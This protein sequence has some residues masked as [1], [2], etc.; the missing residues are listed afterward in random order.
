[1]PRNNLILTARKV[2]FL[3]WL[4]IAA[5]AL[6]A[7]CWAAFTFTVQPV[8][9][10]IT[11]SSARLYWA[12]S[13]PVTAYIKYGTTPQFGK[14]V[15]TY[16]SDAI[17]PQRNHSWFLS[18]LAANTTYHATVCALDGVEICSSDITFTTNVLPV[19]H[20]VDPELPRLE[21]DTNMPVQTGSILNVGANCDDA[22][23]G[24]VARWTQAAW[25][26][27]VVI[28]VTTVCTG[29]YVFPAKT[30]DTEVPHRWIVTKSS[31]ADTDL[32]P[33]GTRITP[34][35]AAY[36]ASVRSNVTNISV[37]TL[38]ARDLYFKCW[39]GAYFW[40]Y[41]QP[42]FAMHQCRNGSNPSAITAVSGSGISPIAI[43]APNHGLVTGDVVWVT[44]IEGNTNANGSFLV[45]VVNANEV[46]LNLAI[47]GSPTG[48]AAYTGGGTIA[49]NVWVSLTAPTGTSVPATCTTGEWFWKSN[50]STAQKGVY[51][52]ISTDNLV[53]M[54]AINFSEFKNYPAIQLSVNS[55][56]HLRF[57]GLQLSNVQP[58]PEPLWEQE[59]GLQAGSA[60]P[61]L[62]F[63]DST[64]KYIVWDRCLFRGKEPGRAQFGGYFDGEHIAVID[65]WFDGFQNWQGPTQRAFDH[66]GNAIMIGY[67][68]GPGKIHNNHLEAY[69]I[70]L[71][72]PD[73]GNSTTPA[74]ADYTVTQNLI[75]HSEEYR[76]GSP[77]S[78]GRTYMVRH[79]FELKRGV[80]WLLEGN[81][82]DGNWASVNNAAAIVLSPRPGPGVYVLSVVAGAVTT[83]P[84][85]GLGVG[86]KVIFTGT[87]GIWTVAAVTDATHLTLAS[88]GSLNAG[89]GIYMNRVDNTST[90]S[91]ITI[92]KNVIKRANAG[93]FIIGH[94]DGGSYPN[95]QS[96]IL[97]RLKMTDNLFTGLNPSYAIPNGSFPNGAGGSVFYAAYGAEDVQFTHNT[98]MDNA[99]SVVTFAFDLISKDNPGE[100]FFATDN[101][102]S[103]GTGSG[104]IVMS[105][106]Y[107]GTEALDRSWTSGDSS[108]WAFQNNVIVR[109]GGAPSVSYPPGNVWHDLSGGDVPF[110]A[111]GNF[112]LAGKYVA[113]AKCF[114][115]LGDC[116]T[117]GK[118]IGMNV[119]ALETALGGVANVRLSQSGQTRAAVSYTAPEGYRCAVDY[120]TNAGFAGKTRLYD[121]GGN[122]SRTVQLSGL[123]PTSSYFVRVLCGTVK[124]IP[125]FQTG[126]AGG[127]AD[128]NFEL[129][130]PSALG[131]A[132][133]IVD[134]GSTSTL[135]SSTSAV[136]CT[137]GCTVT[138]PA[139]TGAALHYR[140]RYLAASGSPLATSL[141]QSY[142]P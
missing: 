82:I 24:L 37:S 23:T 127:P 141:I 132:D 27:T 115:I 14:V 118:D 71:Y 102:L 75:Y 56:H 28:P 91:D 111:S 64:N 107:F 126:S 98:V 2:W 12:T 78:N 62:V 136:P 124:T 8:A 112:R 65:S 41:D 142:L 110:Q 90:I 67:G 1:M 129:H 69:G 117:D 121:A 96:P 93:I 83:Y 32:P 106:T 40:A 137:F 49:K 20:P 13:N 48:N 103:Y 87:Q 5:L 97:A 84:P 94:T 55:A 52:C 89:A 45:T 57:I 11:H 58:P 33:P 21:V 18:G 30:A 68:P 125:V 128:V 104:A 133:V 60:F 76:Y 22:A 95:V 131:V 113:A 134:Y 54:P 140:L 44:G 17:P 42:G 29:S 36:T 88:A 63:Q 92:R 74:P 99:P 34:D 119:T 109:S 123:L 59:N 73:D 139:T 15:R 39:A 43:T 101:L 38:A 53:S 135:G 138:V 72:S 51:R 105:G 35:F 6:P 79:P 19:Q 26:D 130:P 66:E 85:H 4:S 47:Y 70:T 108:A 81:T 16:P 31:G 10:A 46:Q 77:S 116:S 114:N 50:A 61:P 80:R 86:Q 25:G 122:R 9:D 3:V 7:T 100:G 120:S